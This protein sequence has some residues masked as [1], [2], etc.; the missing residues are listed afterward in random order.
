MKIDE[1]TK[2]VARLHREV[3]FRANSIYNPYLQETGVNALYL[4]FHNPDPAPLVQGLKN[5]NLSGAIPAGFEKDPRLVPLMDELGPVA[6]E[7]KKVGLIVQRNGKNTGY[8]QGGYGLAESIN[9]LT[10][11]SGKRV[12][13][14][15]AGQ[16][17]HAT[18]RVWNLTKTEPKE[19][20]IYNRTI[21]KGEK[22]AEKF[23]SIIDVRPIK[24]LPQA[25]GDLFVNATYAGS[26]WGKQDDSLFTERLVKNFNYIADVTFVPLEPRLIKFAKKLKKKYSPGWNMFLYQGKMCLEKILDIKVKEDI[27]AKHIVKD[28]KTNWL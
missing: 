13:F 9:R 23:P 12:V 6:R 11:I 20:V 27:L 19:I 16:V 15:G 8:Y 25:E 4:L 14:F 5:L 2:I 22:L 21:V 17:V 18:L 1:H 28:F 24:E 3:N 26:P 10:N 7:I